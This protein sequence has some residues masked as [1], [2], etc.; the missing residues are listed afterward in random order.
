[1]GLNGIE[2]WYSTTEWR[3]AGGC[4]ETNDSQSENGDVS[5]Q[6]LK[7]DWHLAN[8]EKGF[9]NFVNPV[10]DSQPTYAYA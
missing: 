1:M 4:V 9:D 5:L 3:R 7:I 6:G 10:S 8:L 2:R